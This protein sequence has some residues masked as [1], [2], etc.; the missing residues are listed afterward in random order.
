MICPFAGTEKQ[1]LLET[2]NLS[3]R[4]QLLIAMLEMAV[5]SSAPTGAQH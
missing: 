5:H 1:A 4:T 3:S 2:E